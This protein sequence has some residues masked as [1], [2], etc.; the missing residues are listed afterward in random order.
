MG[1][2]SRVYVEQSINDFGVIV[3]DDGSDPPLKQSLSDDSWAGLDLE[4]LT[5]R[6]HWTGRR[7]KCG[8]KPETQEFIV[9]VDDDVFASRYFVEATLAAVGRSF[10]LGAPVVSLRTVCSTR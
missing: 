8:S 5:R 1:V 6:T 10:E 2:A 3:V 9:F 7:S 4:L